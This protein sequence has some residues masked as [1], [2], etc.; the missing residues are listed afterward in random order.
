MSDNLPAL[1]D[2]APRINAEHEACHAARCEC[3]CFFDVNNPVVLLT[4][5]PTDAESLIC[6]LENLREEIM[7]EGRADLANA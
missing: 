6:D 7:G 1:E 3:P 5:L 2:L 4:G